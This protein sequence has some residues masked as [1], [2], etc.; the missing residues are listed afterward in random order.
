[1]KISQEKMLKL[2]DVVFAAFDYARKSNGLMGNDLVSEGLIPYR[3]K[4]YV[5]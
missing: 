4:I 2:G 1:M 3:Q 5:V